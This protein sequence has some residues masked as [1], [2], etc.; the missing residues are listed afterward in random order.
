MDYQEFAKIIYSAYLKLKEVPPP[1]FP[2]DI[3]IDA[4]EL[5]IRIGLLHKFVYNK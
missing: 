2:L 1:V 3:D 5:S 4:I